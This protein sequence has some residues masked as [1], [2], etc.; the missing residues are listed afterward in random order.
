MTREFHGPLGGPEEGQRRYWTAVI[1]KIYLVSCFSISLVRR[2]ISL[3]NISLCFIPKSYILQ[4]IEF[5]KSE[6][7]AEWD[8]NVTH[9]NPIPLAFNCYPIF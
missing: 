4:C 1:V 3:S 2:L 7:T 9:L 5:K 6:G 8:G